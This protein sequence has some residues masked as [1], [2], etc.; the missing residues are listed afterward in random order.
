MCLVKLQ[1]GQRQRRRQSSCWV[2]VCWYLGVGVYVGW[3]L[4]QH[5]YDVPLVVV[6]SHVQWRQTV[7]ASYIHVSI[8]VLQQQQPTSVHLTVLSGHMQCR[9]TVL[10]THTHTQ[11]SRVR[12]T[13][14]IVSKKPR[15]KLLRVNDQMNTNRLHSPS[16]HAYDAP[17]CV[18]MLSLRNCQMN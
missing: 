18:C 4:Q 10:R 8:T 11:Q 2:V 13:R 3:V 7:L 6:S 1:W 15:S 5:D 14:S 16:E 9:E 17:Q 12:V